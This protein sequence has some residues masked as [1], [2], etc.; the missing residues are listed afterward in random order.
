MLYIST[1][2]PLWSLSQT[3]AF[4]MGFIKLCT[5]Q[6][7]PTKQPTLEQNQMLPE[8]PSLPTLSAWQLP[9]YAFQAFPF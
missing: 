4:P 9:R 2:H 5:N 3:P 6:N 7:L 8:S 1:L